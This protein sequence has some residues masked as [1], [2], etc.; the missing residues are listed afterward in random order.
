VNSKSNIATVVTPWKKYKP[1]IIIIKVS[2]SS[3][4]ATVMLISVRKRAVILKAN[5]PINPGTM[6]IKKYRK[7]SKKSI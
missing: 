3:I 7:R 5:A 1:V 4:N 6:R 2:K